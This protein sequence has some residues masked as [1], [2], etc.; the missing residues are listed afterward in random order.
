MTEQPAQDSALKRREVRLWTSLL[1]VVAIILSTIWTSGAF[2]TP[3]LPYL[4]AIFGL[5]LVI[6]SALIARSGSRDDRALAVAFALAL[7]FIAF[8]VPLRLVSSAERSHLI[9]YCAVAVLLREALRVRALRGHAVARPTLVT[10]FAV[11]LIGLADEILQETV[12]TRH[13]DWRDIF[14]NACAAVL[15]LAL[16]HLGRIV[17]GRW[18][19]GSSNS[20]DGS[21][22]GT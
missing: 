6:V 1:I 4:F 9:E 16:Y 12:A 13:F 18:S 22:G 2:P 7:A 20:E 19:A 5:A 21:G 10:L 3:A 11:V 14:V 17:T 8:M 15:G